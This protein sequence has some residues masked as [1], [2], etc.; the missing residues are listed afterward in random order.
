MWN[1]HKNQSKKHACHKKKKK[2]IKNLCFPYVA[3]PESPI[4]SENTTVQEKEKR[5]TISEL[6]WRPRF[7]QIT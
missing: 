2:K 6:F 3:K 4:Y 5:T 1:S 7:R